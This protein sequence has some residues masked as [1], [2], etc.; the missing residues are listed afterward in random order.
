MLLCMAMGTVLMG[1]GCG[2]VHP[3]ASAA[4]TPRL[5]S[6]GEGKRL[7]LHLPYRFQF[8]DV[9]LPDGASGAIAGTVFGKHKTILRFGISFGEDPKAVPVPGVGTVDPYDYSSAAGFVFNDDMEVPG[10]NESVHPGPQYHT[11]AQWHEAAK[12]VVEMQQTFC[13]AATGKA[14]PV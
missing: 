12:I 13:R 3:T 7:L 10:K 2:A 11:E 9:R 4:N 8:R 1:S 6:S 14:C 5:L